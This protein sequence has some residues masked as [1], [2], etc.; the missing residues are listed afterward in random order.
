MEAKGDLDLARQLLEATG[1]QERMYLHL[2]IL[3]AARKWI[4]KIA[5]SMD[6]T[7][8]ACQC[9]LCIAARRVISKAKELDIKS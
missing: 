7:K 9:H 4:D 2:M 5:P 6:H 1:I 3:S 8:E